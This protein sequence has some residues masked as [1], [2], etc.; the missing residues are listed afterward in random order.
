L[1]SA[2]TTSTAMTVR[3]ARTEFSMRSFSQD[4]AA[5]RGW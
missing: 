5:P 1:N 3:S 2:V 4:W